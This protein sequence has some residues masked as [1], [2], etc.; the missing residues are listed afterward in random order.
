MKTARVSPFN[1]DVR[2]MTEE[3]EK[4]RIAFTQR[5]E[6][7]VAWAMARGYNPVMV[8][9]VLAG[10]VQCRNGQAHKIAVDLGLKPAA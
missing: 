3:R 10:R 2:E 7:M 9:H 1:H 5:G 4:A 6:S 8:G